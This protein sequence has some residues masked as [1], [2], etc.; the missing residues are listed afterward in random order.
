MQ[1][2]INKYN[3]NF[4]S[5]SQLYSNFYHLIYSLNANSKNIKL[6]HEIKKIIIKMVADMVVLLGSFSGDA[7]L[8]TYKREYFE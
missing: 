2:F 4:L 3:T 6:L 7:Y 8:I 1:F 5:E